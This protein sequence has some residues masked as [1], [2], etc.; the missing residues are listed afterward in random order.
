[1][2]PTTGAEPAMRAESASHA[3]RA[4]LR[5]Y[6]RIEERLR[7]ASPAL[8]R[9]A[10]IDALQGLV[11]AYAALE[12][13]LEKH[14]TRLAQI[15]IDGPRRRKTPLLRADLAALD[16]LVADRS[17][18]RVPCLPTLA[19]ALGCMYVMEGA[20]LGGMAIRRNVATVLG[21]GPRDGAT[22]FASYGDAVGVHWQEFC[23]ALE[24]GLPDDNARR[25]AADSAVATFATIEAC[26]IASSNR[27]TT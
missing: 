16:E 10:Y 15:G 14:A 4:A 9:R 12:A 25:E 2:Q 7:L 22:F 19:A 6:G 27:Q 3:L 8:T 26:L 20:T 23:A 21:L 11:A 18:P 5:P 1:M 24:R 13:R 17:P